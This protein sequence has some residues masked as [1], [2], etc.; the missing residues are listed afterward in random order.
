MLMNFEHKK[1]SIN[2]CGKVTIKNYI[3]NENKDFKVII[4]FTIFVSKKIK[5]N[6]CIFVI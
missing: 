4:I 5:W 1:L 3:K 6:F 2:L